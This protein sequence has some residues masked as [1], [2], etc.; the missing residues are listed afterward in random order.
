MVAILENK[1][2]LFMYLETE[3][4]GQSIPIIPSLIPGR[5]LEDY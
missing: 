2:E 5:N 3:F 4:H 1:I